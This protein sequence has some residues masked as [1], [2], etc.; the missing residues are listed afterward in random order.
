M[1]RYPVNTEM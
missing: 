1:Q